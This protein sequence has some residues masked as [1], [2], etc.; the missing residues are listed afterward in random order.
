MLI[1]VRELADQDV[2]KLEVP[3]ALEAAL[4]DAHDLQCPITLEIL[5][6]PCSLDG[7]VWA[8]A[9]DVGSLRPHRD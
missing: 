7:K 3:P 9:I 4:E 8:L 2:P 1:S 6:D 5:V